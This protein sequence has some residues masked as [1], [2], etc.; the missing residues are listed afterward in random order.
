MVIGFCIKSCSVR[1]ASLCWS[2]V[3][4]GSP[5]KGIFG[6]STAPEIAATPNT[7]TTGTRKRFTTGSSLRKKP[8][9]LASRC[10]LQRLSSAG[11]KVRVAAN[12]TSMPKPAMT[13]NWATP[14][15]RVGEKARKPAAV[16]RAATRICAP[17]RRPVS[18]SASTM[19][20]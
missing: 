20:G 7:T 3:C 5:S 16:A 9:S 17:L 2:L 8:T 1:T 19:S 14:M 10:G 6:A 15:K 4:N 12:A 13:P 18:R 11:R